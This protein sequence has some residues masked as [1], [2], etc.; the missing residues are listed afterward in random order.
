MKFITS[1]F[2]NSMWQEPNN[3]IIET[4]LTEENFRE[5]IKGAKSCVT[6]HDVAE[7]LGVEL[8]HEP[9]KARPEDTIYNVVWKPTGFVYYELFLLQKEFSDFLIKWTNI[10]R[11]HSPEKEITEE[12]LFNAIMQDFFDRYSPEEICQMAIEE[13]YV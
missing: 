7:H 11:E 1:S 10:L 2:S 8:N 6:N 3:F 9:V 5:A 13:G 12:K 4:E